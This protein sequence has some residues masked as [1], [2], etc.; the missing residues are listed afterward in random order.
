MDEIEREV[1]LELELELDDWGR[2]VVSE[3]DECG[4][5]LGWVGLG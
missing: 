3:L 1:V 4:Q 5:E 2:E